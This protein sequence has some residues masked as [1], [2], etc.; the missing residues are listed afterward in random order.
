MNTNC[1]RKIS[2]LAGFLVVL[3]LGTRL[4]AAAQEVETLELIRA[5]EAGVVEVTVQ[6]TRGLHQVSACVRSRQGVPIQLEVLPG[7][8]FSTGDAEYQR[9]GVTH[10]VV[11]RLDAREEKQILVP[12]ACLDMEL[13]QPYEGM[14]F[15][16][17]IAQGDSE[18]VRRLISLPEF[19]GL[20]FRIRQFALW[21][22]ITQPAARENYPGLG[23]GPDVI[24]ALVDYGIPGDII[25]AFYYVPGIVYAMPL[26]GLMSLELLFAE[27]GI[28]VEGA[29]E[30]FLLFSAGRPTMQELARIARLL[31][32]AGIPLDG[33]IAT[34]VGS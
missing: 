22:A 17:G 29:D 27:V 14:T 6:A 15:R 7:T 25:T 12:V 8:V 18:A 31:D 3:T 16:G 20:T 32:L 13:E 10:H 24:N 2:I 5:H 34:A 30:L 21:T 23:L 19:Q 26:P 28:P 33:F 11:V 1:G 9:M 4:W